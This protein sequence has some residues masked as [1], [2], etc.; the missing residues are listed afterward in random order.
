[1]A[2]HCLRFVV[3]MLEP[4]LDQGGQSLRAFV[5]DTL[6]SLPL[7]LQSAATQELLN[8]LEHDRRTLA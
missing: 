5:H 6:C 8:A 7:K 1:M 2:R 3:G 4:H